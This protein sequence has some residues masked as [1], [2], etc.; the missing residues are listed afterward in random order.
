MTLR[1]EVE[2]FLFHDSELL[3]RWALH[4]WLALFTPDCEYL[5]PA[6]DC[7]DGDPHTDLFFVRDDHFLLSQRVDAIMSGTAW[8][9]SPRS[10]THRMLS[11]VRAVETGDGTIEA[12][13]NLL[14]H[15]SANGRLD[16]YPAHLSFV[17]VPGGTAGFMVRRRL[18]V[19]AM[20]QLRPHGRLSIIL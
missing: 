10:T 12:R 17:L 7:P 1:F 4:E 9:E 2:D 14:V 18:A 8:A 6:T 11:N 19:L 16:A 13:A 20:E 5:V 3:D 15:R